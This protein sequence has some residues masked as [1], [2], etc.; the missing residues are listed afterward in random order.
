MSRPWSAASRTS[1]R[2]SAGV[3]G[4]S[5]LSGIVSRPQ[6][7]GTNAGSSTSISTKGPY[8]VSEKTMPYGKEWLTSVI[9]DETESQDYAYKRKRQVSQKQFPKKKDDDIAN[10][11]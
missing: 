8:F 2:A 4:C 7:A 11:E 1:N 10:D 9:H 6:S 5:G 3:R